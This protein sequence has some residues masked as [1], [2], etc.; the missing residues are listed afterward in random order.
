[1]CVN[2]LNAWSL[3]T[4][5]RG[6]G[7]GPPRH[8]AVNYESRPLHSRVFGAVDVLSPFLDK[9]AKSASALRSS[10]DFWEG[11]KGAQRAACGLHP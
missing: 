1:M 2:F 9:E 7:A 11:I 6:G 10:S 3:S 5:E 8:L 4:F